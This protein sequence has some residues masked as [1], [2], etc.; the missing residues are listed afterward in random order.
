MTTLLGEGIF[1]I[2]QQRFYITID[3]LDEN[4]VDERI[5]YK[6]LRA[7]LEAV[8]SFKQVRSVKVSRSRL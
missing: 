4:W 8:R 7:L 2:P 3:R 5:R 6:L 1:D